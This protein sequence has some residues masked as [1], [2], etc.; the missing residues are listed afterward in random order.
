METPTC[1]YGRQCLLTTYNAYVHC[2]IC[3]PYN[4]FIFS[5]NKKIQIYSKNCTTKLLT[6]EHMAV[7]VVKSFVKILGLWIYELNEVLLY[8]VANK[9]TLVL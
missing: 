3:Y 2:W 1:E 7:F 6:I 5:N 8:A 9:N 4:L